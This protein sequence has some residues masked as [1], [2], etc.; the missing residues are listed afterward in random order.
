MPQVRRAGDFRTA[1]ALA[2]PGRLFVHNA[3]PSFPASW[4]RQVYGAAGAPEV[5]HIQPEEAD[6]TSVLNWVTVGS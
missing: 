5:L 3:A 1:A 6:I 2:A 4:F